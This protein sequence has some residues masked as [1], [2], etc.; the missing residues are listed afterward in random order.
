MNKKGLSL[1]EI[2]IVIIVLGIALVPLLMTYANVAN[3]GMQR[4]AITIATSLAQTLMEEIESKRYD[5]NTA[6]PWSATLG[7]ET[8]ET[9]RAT[10]ND[11]DDFNGYSENPIPN[12]GGYSLSVSVSYVQ[13]G[14]LE[15]PVVGTTTDFKRIMV[16][17]SHSK[18]GNVRLVSVRQPY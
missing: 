3:T 14:D 17:V 10:Y 11:V 4:E 16:T 5:E 12:F 8:G 6:P 18:A 15:T 7:S 13:P 1:I 9:G 2:V